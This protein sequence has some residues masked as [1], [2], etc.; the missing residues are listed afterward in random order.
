MACAIFFVQAQK[1][2]LSYDFGE[3]FND[4]HK[5]SN[6][7]TIAE[8]GDG[9]YI[10]VRSYFQ[11]LILRPKGYL[12]ERYDADLNLVSEYNYKFRDMQFVDSFVQDGVLN[13]LFFNYDYERGQYEYWVH[14]SATTHFEFS[15]ERLMSI[16]SKVVEGALGKNY[17]NRNFSNG[18][19][20]TVLFDTHK[21]GFLISTHHTKG[22]KSK[23]TMHLFDAQLNK[24]WEHDFTAEVE[25]K[26]YAFEQLALSSDLNT[27]YLVGKA[28]YKKKRF[29]A[30]ERKFQYELVRVSNNTSM[31]QQ[32]NESGK[33]PEALYP[34]LQGNKLKCVGFYADRK[35][36]RYNGLVYYE[37]NGST[38]DI[39]K[40]R[41]NAFSKKFMFD[42]FG[43]EEDQVIKNL[44]FKSVDVTPDNEIFFNAEEFFVTHSMH[45]TG[46]GQR[47]TVERFH[48]N[49]IVSAK[50]DV[51]G[52]MIW[53]RNINK[54]EVTQGDGAYASYSAYFKNGKTF[55]FI[56]TAAEN[57]Q[58]INK[59]RVVFKQGLSRN[60]N[61]FV[62]A[63]DEKGQ[64][65][66]EKII[67]SQ[68]ARLPLMVSKPYI[69]KTEDQLL[70]YAKRGSKKQLVEVEFN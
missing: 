15:K 66:Y 58:L 32:F 1:I 33:Y 42:K 50:L 8:D 9:G 57:P 36:N 17:Y 2:P 63:L 4:R 48:H 24:R 37:L 67:D 44:V 6:L 49:D 19:T 16:K 26:N 18:F 38:L 27:A 35:D 13:L 56:C 23:H 64:M 53:A 62:I 51:S 41:Y 28:Y 46:A 30:E 70:F 29:K 40:S 34:I 12:I 55:F 61:V 54:L 52:K 39:E 47:M 31:N 43:R 69:D 7:Q 5:Y 14:R 68:E 20:T 22:K 10:L 21:K 60:R 59:E 45:R 3:K 11:G 25:E 65:E